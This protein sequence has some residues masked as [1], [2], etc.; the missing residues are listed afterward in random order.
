MSDSDGE[1]AL[2]IVRTVQVVRAL[3]IIIDSTLELALV[4][5]EDPDGGAPRPVGAIESFG[6]QAHLVRNEVL[7]ATDDINVVNGFLSRWP[8]ELLETVAME[9]TPDLHTFSV[10]TSDVPLDNLEQHIDMISGVTFGEMLF[11]S[12]DVLKLYSIVAEEIALNDL[13]I[14][15]NWVTL[16]QS[17]RSGSTQEETNSSAADYTPDAFAW[18]YMNKLSDQNTGVTAAWQTLDL[19]G[20]NR[21]ERVMVIDSGFLD[22]GDYFNA[23]VP[24]GAGWGSPSRAGCTS[25]SCLWHGTEVAHVAAGVPDNGV[26]VA[27]SAGVHAV[28]E[29]VQFSGFDL[30]GLGRIF[31]IL[32]TAPLNGP[33]AVVNISGSVSVPAPFNVFLNRFLDPLFDRGLD[34]GIVVVVSAGND[35]ND[36]DESRRFLLRTIETSTV[37]PCETSSVVCVGGLAWDSN[38]LDG[39]SNFGSEAESDSVDIYASFEYWVPVID[40]DGVDRQAVKRARGTSF[41]APFVSGVFA[42]MKAANPGISADNAIDCLLR[43]AH[44]DDGVLVHSGG[45]NQRRV[46]AFESVVCALGRRAQ[47]PLLAIDSPLDGTSVRGRADLSLNAVSMGRDGMP[48]SITWRSDR[49]GVIGTFGPDGVS[50]SL[51]VGTHNLTAEVTD[52]DGTTATQTVSVTVTNN[53]PSATILSPENGESFGEMQ[54]IPLLGL[55]EDIDARPTGQLAGSQIRWSLSGNGFTATGANAT[56]PAGRLGIGT[57]TLTMLADDETDSAQDSVTCLLYTSPSPRD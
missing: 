50:T 40:P 55:A 25:D 33:P 37:V 46:D 26:G 38:S 29:P 56:I 35:G 3:D 11:S 54:A 5:V 34:L 17:I 31:G 39:D 45:G 24:A 12:D 30:R 8:A 23:F 6:T 41:S 53:P 43:S 15:L 49:D 52:S 47:F 32:L 16:N 42:M 9:G 27:G 57:Y 48:L 10:D 7:I 4:D 21:A 1:S 2:E 19:L 22:I 13:T 51:S 20:I 44:Q 18:P 14:T 28:L 36:V